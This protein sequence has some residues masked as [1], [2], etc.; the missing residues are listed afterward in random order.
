MSRAPDRR[1]DPGRDGPQHQERNHDKPTTNAE[2]P[3]QQASQESDD[4]ETRP[5]DYSV[6]R[7][8]VSGWFI[9]TEW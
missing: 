5:V 2:Q 3:A 1:A 9:T 6:V 7:G 4:D 8:G